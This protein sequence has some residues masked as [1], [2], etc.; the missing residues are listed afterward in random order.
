MRYPV[1]IFNDWSE[2]GFEDDNY[3]IPIDT[4]N[5]VM[6]TSKLGLFYDGPHF[7]CIF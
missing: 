4:G 2:Y 5:Y 3:P 6:I 7:I 1:D